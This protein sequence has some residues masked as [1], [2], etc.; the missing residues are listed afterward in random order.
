MTEEKK[1]LIICS[2]QGQNVG[3]LVFDHDL[4]CEAILYPK[5]EDL[6]GGWLQG[7]QT[8]GINY[9]HP[10][11]SDSNDICTVGESVNMHDPV[12]PS[13][14]RQWLENK[15]YYSFILPESGWRAWSLIQELP[16]HEGEKLKL[17]LSLAEEAETKLQKITSQLEC[18]NKRILQD[19]SKKARTSQRK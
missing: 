19:A 3:E 1:R 9:Y 13:A 5:G 11:V 15:G 12:F 14:L 18:L 4:F 7:W 17:G 6:L 2:L 16:L 8:T 10:E